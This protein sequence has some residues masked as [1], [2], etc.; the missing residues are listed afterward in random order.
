MTYPQIKLDPN[1][2]TGE[3]PIDE[4][5]IVWLDSF[6]KFLAKSSDNEPNPISASQIRKFFGEVKKIEAD[7]ERRKGDVILL[8]PKLAYS[9]GKDYSVRSGRASSKIKEFYEELTRGIDKVNSTK[10]NF[11]NFVKLLEGIVAY[12][13]FYGGKI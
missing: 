9:V 13:R 4:S 8:K 6:G 12:H 5:V 3:K 11:K 7:F 10:S 2:I 1:W